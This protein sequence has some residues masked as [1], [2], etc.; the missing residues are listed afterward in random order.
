MATNNAI[1]LQSAGLAKYDGAGTFS[2][3]TLTLHCPLIGGAS[4]A[5]TS[6]GPLTNG[7]LVIG[8]TGNDPAAATLTPGSGILI[9]NGAGSIQLDVTGGGMT[10]TVITGASQAMAVNN[11]YGAND[12]S[13]LVAFSLPVTAALGSVVQV[14]GMSSG[15]GWT[16]TQGA[17]QQINI[18]IGATTLGA[19]GSLASTQYTD[20][21][22]LK[23]LVAN[24]FF[25]ATSVIG[26]ITVT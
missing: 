4:N 9:T 16:I 8:N 20:A 3:V 2:G 14:I 12:G 23:C 11:S 17:G 22:T 26:N 5:I 13:A 19:G 18:G 1:N 10:T 21:I 25:Y 7:Q 15:K 24:T 6:L